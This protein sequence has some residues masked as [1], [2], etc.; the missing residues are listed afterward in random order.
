MS[1]I[2]VTDAGRI[3]A[4]E[5]LDLVIVPQS[6]L[7]PQGPTKVW[8]CHYQGRMAVGSTVREVI[9]LVVLDLGVAEL[10]QPH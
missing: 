3:N 7:T 6:Q 5:E 9:D 2:D 10:L 4:I 8:V 1:V